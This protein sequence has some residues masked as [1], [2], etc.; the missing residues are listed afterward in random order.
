VATANSNS[1]EI[2][3]DNAP[4]AVRCLRCQDFLVVD[5]DRLPNK[6]ERTRLEFLRDINR[7]ATFDVALQEYRHGR[8][9]EYEAVAK[10]VLEGGYGEKDAKEEIRTILGAGGSGR[11]K[12]RGGR[13]LFE[14]W[15]SGGRGRCVL[16]R[17][18]AASSRESSGDSDRL[19]EFAHGECGPRFSWC[20]VTPI[21][22]L[23]EKRSGRAEPSFLGQPRPTPVRR[24]LV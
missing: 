4:A 3:D 14:K 22:H 23:K 16:G 18:R 21:S 24:Y 7:Q 6:K 11:A 12:R 13:R 9:S 19:G 17:T 15:L 20:C 2:E 5:F 10:I 1:L 8:L